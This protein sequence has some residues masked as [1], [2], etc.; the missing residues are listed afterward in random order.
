[1]A[2][3][4]NP[5]TR[6][7]SLGEIARVF[8]KIGLLGFGGPAAHIA[9]MEEEVVRR[10]KWLSTQDFVDIVGATNLIP[11]PN[12]TEMAIHLG[13]RMQGWRGWLTAGSSFIAPAAT[14][15]GILAWAY[16]RYGT[17]PDV[18]PLLEGIKPA[19]PAIIGVAVWNLGKKAVK[20]W[21]QGVLAAAVL[22]LSCLGVNEVALILGA[23]AAGLLWHVLIHRKGM[24]CLFPFLALPLNLAPASQP[25]SLQSLGLFFLKIGCVLFGSGYVLFAFLESE[26]VRE[27]GWLTARELIDAVAVGQFTPGPIL[28][29]A[30]FVGYL[31]SDWQGA[32]V[33]TAAIFFPSFLFV[34]LL[35]PWVPKLRGNPWS[36]AFLDA[37]NAGAVA[38]MAAVVIRLGSQVLSD[39]A[40]IGIAGVSLVLLYRFKLNGGLL[41]VLAAAAGVILSALG[42]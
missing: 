15:T 1:M 5:S 22:G 8:L 19:V 9:M 11:G 33:A 35:S 28:S 23:G 34:L 6:R 17:L 25:V 3:T 27:K 2:T 10:R 36:A 32:L 39:I 30:T 20:G 18:A 40:S 13:L 37:V 24:A 26:L 42:L 21:E 4:R 16:R 7:P 12:S 14:L 38:L 41:V 29:T 31:V